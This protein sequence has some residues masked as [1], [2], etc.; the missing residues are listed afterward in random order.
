VA[1]RKGRLFVLLGI[2]RDRCATAGRISWREL[3]LGVLGFEAGL[4][5]RRIKAGTF[6][7]CS[8]LERIVV[9][10][11]VASLTVGLFEFAKD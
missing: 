3:L 5:L 2:A 6:A 9:P 1:D 11:G 4:L 8:R 10:R 7:A